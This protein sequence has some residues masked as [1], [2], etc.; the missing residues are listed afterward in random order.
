M[1]FHF[2]RWRV[3][4]AAFVAAFALAGAA[5]AQ[6]RAPKPGP[7][8]AAPREPG[9]T[10]I[11][12][13]YIEGIGGQETTARGNAELR[14]DD[15]V[16][17]GDFL[18]YN[19][20]FGR[21]EAD[22]GVR[23]QQGNDR[24]SGPR[25][26]YDSRNHTGVFEE[27]SFLLRG[28]QPARGKAERIE[29]LGPGH[30][31]MK[32]G[33]YTSCEPGND[34]WRFDMGE[35]DI[36]YDTQ[37]GTLRNGTL[38][39]FDAS[40]GPIPWIS[41]PLEN[42]RKSGFLSPTY[43]QSTRGG[44]ELSLPFYWNIAPE[45]DA[46]ITPRYISRRGSMLLNEYRYIDPRY[47]GE[48]HYE[49]LPNDQLAQL[50]RTGFSLTHKQTFSPALMGYL[51]L[52]KVSDDRYF[53]DLFSKVS[54][55]STVN[56][57]Q[58]GFLQYTGSVSGTGYYL[59]S[60]IQR[61][62]T[63]Q[64]PLS[65]VVSPY[66]RVPQLSFGTAKN[67]IAGL[68]D[69]VLP[70]EYVR[71]THPTLVEGQRVVMNPTFTAPIVAPGYFITPKVGLHYAG[72]NLLNAPAGT[73]DRQSVSIPWFSVDSGLVFERNLKL[74]GESFAQTLEPRLFYVHIPFRDQNQIPVFDTGL[75]DFNYSSIFTENRFAG[76]DRFGDA[77]QLTAALTTR[78]LGSSSGRELLRAT[79]A[80][81]FYFKNEQVGLTPTS[82]L[83]TYGSSDLLASVGGRI[84]QAWSFETAYEY[85]QR[86]T[87]TERFNAAM[88][89]SPEIAKVINLGYRF[90]RDTLNQVDISG[91]WPLR[92][93]WYAIGRYNYSFKD[94]QL[95]EGIAGI[96]YNAGCWILRVVG[97][98][99]QAATQL[100][101]STFFV[102]IELNELGRIGSDPTDLLRRTVAGYTSTRLQ[103]DQPV[104]LSLQP[105][106][107][108]PMVY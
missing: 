49:V 53:V 43:T 40:I 105:K 21:I 23:L 25:L 41:F 51:N 18:R 42:R 64:D 29:F 27:P 91:Q 87:R 78:L 59:Q 48:M 95:L 16:I 52:N 7:T 71:F 88:R 68:G 28:D 19:Q 6:L 24:F 82:D 104:P 97:H 4:V 107:P 30:F 96:E 92:P 101:S 39:F 17:F 38:R 46:T 62:Q 12:A 10:T 11:D 93:R 106:L 94:A 102:Q 33:T 14:Q 86:E 44:L 90:T 9:P 69:A 34:D 3:P 57:L 15:T 13:D 5:Q 37:T 2:A 89:Y 63:L 47:A 56:L 103:P 1:Q 31:R 100:A 22:G 85:N 66:Q 79:I 35:L 80:Q 65:P 36:D 77:N 81:R 54:Q 20:E 32:N 70:I 76:G 83:R 61:F 74:A 73:P 8:P 99:L 67:D 26:R 58:E 108:F 45:Q 50:T 98:R 72:Y 60:R 75:S 84:S 55:T